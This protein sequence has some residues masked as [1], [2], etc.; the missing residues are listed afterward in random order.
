MQQF[1]EALVGKPP[2]AHP[3]RAWHCASGVDVVVGVC[4]EGHLDI[5]ALMD[6]VLMRQRG[7]VRVDNPCDF[8]G[9]A[10]PHLVRNCALERLLDLLVVAAS[11]DF[12]RSAHPAETASRRSS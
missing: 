1:V 4:Q 7:A 9:A 10:A 8:I 3:L 5:E 12:R 6:E 2:S 11:T